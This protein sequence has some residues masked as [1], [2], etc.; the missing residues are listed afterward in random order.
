MNRT[1]P[2]SKC[3]LF[4]ALVSFS[5]SIIAKQTL[6]NAD[7]MLDVETGK[8]IKNVA[9]LIEDNKI[10]SVGKQGKLTV[11]EDAE[12]IDLKGKTLVP[13]LM[14]MHVHLTSDAKDNFLAKRG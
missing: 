6:L 12:I 5:L 13:G 3:I 11:A 7:S 10:V 2:Y 4:V 1:R 9:V 14:D 8:I